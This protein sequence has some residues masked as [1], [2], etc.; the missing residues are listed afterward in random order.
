MNSP[1]EEL[2]YLAD[3]L[4]DEGEAVVLVRRDGEL[5]CEPYAREPQRSGI[6]PEFYGRLVQANE[7]L[8]A[9]GAVPLWTAA[10]V[11]FWLCVAL[12]KAVGL[13]WQWWSLDAGLLLLGVLGCFVWIRHRQ[14]W[15]YRRE[16]L[17]ML[18]AQFRRRR[19]D[20]FAV[21]GAIRQQ[22]ELRTLLDL[23]TRTGE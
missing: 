22:R 15:L 17:P 11:V 8:D 20:R 4:P 1:F 14:Y 23:M 6:D 7:R 2:E 12:H 9:Q 18:A 21:I 5:V 16:V 19:L 3:H 10:V 13:G